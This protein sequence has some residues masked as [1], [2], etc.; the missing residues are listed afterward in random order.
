[1]PIVGYRPTSRMLPAEKSRRSQARLSISLGRRRSAP[2]STKPAAIPRDTISAIC[3]TSPAATMARVAEV[4]DPASGRVM[5]V[6]TTEPAIVFYTAN[7]LDGTLRGKGGDDLRETR[8][9]LPRNRPPARRHSLSELS[10]HRSAAG[11]DLPPPLRLSFLDEII[12][13]PHH[14]KILGRLS[15]QVWNR[16]FYGVRFAAG[17]SGRGSRPPRGIEPD[18]LRFAWHVALHGIPSLRAGWQG[19]ARS[20][21]QDH[22]GK[23]FD[24]HRRLRPELRPG[25]APT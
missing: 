14:E 1:M 25:R 15:A 13:G 4:F 11:R 7:Y 17:G 6:S 5:E 10:V 24:G 18:G 9:P 2:E 8:R 16:L 22:L 19:Q 20:A 3:G 21:G 23:P 12:F